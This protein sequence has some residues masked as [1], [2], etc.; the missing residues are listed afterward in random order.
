MDD[1]NPCLQAGDDGILYNKN[2]AHLLGIP[3]M[4]KELTIPSGVEEVSI[5]TWNNLEKI[6]LSTEEVSQI[7]EIELKNLHSYCKISMN[8]KVLNDFMDCYETDLEGLQLKTDVED[9]LYTVKDHLAADREGN[10]HYVLKSASKTVRLPETI[11]NIEKQAFSAADTVNLVVPENIDH[12]T[13]EKD[14]LKNS[15]IKVIWCYSAP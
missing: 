14:C 12:L 4:V 13:L 5:P 6:Q 8:E 2:R 7:P 11:K 9:T 15:K 10:L 1:N 3:Y